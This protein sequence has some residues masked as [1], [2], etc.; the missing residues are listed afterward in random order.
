MVKSNNQIGKVNEKKNLIQTSNNEIRKFWNRKKST[1]RPTGPQ[2]SLL[3]LEKFNQFSTSPLLLSSWCKGQSA[4][5]QN[6]LGK[7]QQ[8]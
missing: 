4:H 1:Y 7:G 6:H 2:V 8:V 5:L 3:E